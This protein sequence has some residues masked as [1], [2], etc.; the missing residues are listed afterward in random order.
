[1]SK[2]AITPART[3][4]IIDIFN[5]SRCK[6]LAIVQYYK[7]NA[8]HSFDD[9]T[10]F[11][12]SRSSVN[13]DVGSFSLAPIPQQMSIS[14]DNRG[15]L[16]S[17]N[18]SSIYADVLKRN[19]LLRASVGYNLDD[20]IFFQY[21]VDVSVYE[22]AWHTQVVNNKIYNRISSEVADSGL[23]GISFVK[24]DNG[25]YDAI[26]LEG[27]GYFLSSI[28]DFGIYDVETLKELSMMSDTDKIKV[29][30]RCSSNYNELKNDTIPFIELGN[31]VDGE[32]IFTLPD[33]KE[34]Y[35]QFALVYNIGAWYNDV[36]ENYVTDI[37]IKYS[38]TAEMF[39]AGEFI[40]DSASWSSDYG[41]K[42]VSISARDKFKK[43][44]ETQVSTT[45]YTST[46]IA[47][48]IRDVA[49]R[50]GLIHNDG[51]TEFIPNTG[52]IVSIIGHKDESAI[53]IFEEQMQYLNAKNEFYKLVIS[54]DGYL[55]LDDTP[56]TSD[57]VNFIVTHKKHIFSLSRELDSNNILQRLTVFS[58][59]EKNKTGN[60]QIL[61]SETY[62]TTG[63][64]ILTW[65]GAFVKKRYSIII[66]SGSF[67]VIHFDNEQLEVIISGDNPSVSVTIYGDSVDAEYSGFVGE[68]VLQE[69]AETKDGITKTI[70]NRYIQSDTEARD[71]AEEL[72]KR[73]GGTEKYTCSISIDGFPLLE[74]GDTV[75]ILEQNTNT[76][77]LFSVDAISTTYNA[78][79]ASYK[80][81]VS[82]SSLGFT[83]SSYLYDRNYAMR[84]FFVGAYD[85]F[86]DLTYYDLHFWSE[87]TDPEVYTRNIL[88]SEGGIIPP[89]HPIEYFYYDENSEYDDVIYY[90][91]FYEGGAD[92]TE[93]SR[94]V[95]FS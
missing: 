80:Q 77:E 4:K 27:E 47:Q 57:N 16:Y 93:Y 44:L 6:P 28:F 74:I 18:T 60:E 84:G 83:L 66:T 91:W 37:E 79:G 94:N 40:L 88:F 2:N 33:I 56:K 43:A 54:D 48:I 68:A 55:V 13:K 50:C 75:M 35:F 52:I 34:R 46:D 53:S 59:D 26:R 49:D 95:L 36:D 38:N 42:S 11:S 12:F 19:L 41:G 15:G 14:M 62:I 90:D 85:L 87:E 17:P 10:S 8:W 65:S 24:Y 5:S 58:S 92:P 82:L 3:Q 22:K 78:D 32:K 86:Y 63:T 39:P 25:K 72:I 70:V 71:I 31:T 21:P 89:P 1:M 64:K 61:A 67:E 29:F 81:N 9:V 30:Y 45:A 7:D 76:N 23:N 20:E 73:F 69:Y 51:V